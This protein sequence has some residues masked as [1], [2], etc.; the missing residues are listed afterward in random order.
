MCIWYII[1][2]GD[3]QVMCLII[4]GNEFIE[5]IILIIKLDKYIIE[6]MGLVGLIQDFIMLFIVVIGIFVVIIVVLI[7]IIV[8]GVVILRYIFNKWMYI[9][10]FL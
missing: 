5:I 4:Y 8:V 1:L 10:Y 3:F 7:I 2:I 6:L 9:Q